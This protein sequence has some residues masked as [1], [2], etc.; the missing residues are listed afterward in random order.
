MPLSQK[1]NLTVP[2]VPAVPL[3]TPEPGLQ[4]QIL[5]Y[6]PAMMLVRHTMQKGW[7]GAAHAHPHEQLVYIISG[8]IT[9]TV[10]GKT[11]QAGEGDSF[12]VGSNA[13]H[14]ASALE[15]SVVLDVFT[16]AREDYI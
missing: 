7:Q 8:C 1:A 5:V 14:Q 4:R 15:N 9:A 6:T 2:D 10:E 11:I 13:M 16:P 12:I 3:T